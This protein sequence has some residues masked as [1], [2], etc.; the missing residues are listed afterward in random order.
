MPKVRPLTRHQRIVE[1]SADLSIY[2]GGAMIKKKIKQQTVAE[3]WGITQQALGARIKG[4]N[5]TQ[6]QLM[7]II[8][9]LELT[10]E[11]IITLIRLRR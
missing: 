9:R 2:I 3:D 1:H 10:D 7:D 11:Q 4:C 8:D 5:L 6:G